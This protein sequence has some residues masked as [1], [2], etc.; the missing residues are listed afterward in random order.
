MIRQAI[1]HHPKGFITTVVVIVA[2][3][4]CIPIVNSVIHPDVYLAPDTAM[5]TISIPYAQGSEAKVKTMKLPRG[6]QVELRSRGDIQS[7]VE[8]K[9]TVF[10][11]DNDQ[12][13]GSLE[14]AIQVEYVYPRRL[15]NLQANKHGKLSDVVIRKGERVKVVQVSLDDF[16]AKT[17]HVAWYQVEKNNKTYWISGSHVE[18][19]KKAA[20]KNYGSDIYYSKYWDDYYGKG[21]SKDAYITQID[22]KPREKS[23]YKENP[24]KG[25]TNAVHVSLDNLSKHK[26]YYKSLNDKTGINAIVVELKSDD[27]HVSYKSDVP[28]SYLSKPKEALST[29]TMSKSDVERLIKEYQD[30]GYYMIA[31]IVSFKDSIFASQN[32]KESIVDKKGNLMSLNDEYWPTVYSRKAW[33]YNVDIAKEVAKMGIN[34]IQFD[35]CRF[36]DGLAGE[37]DA[38]NLRNKYDES[39]VSAIQGFL[40]YAYDEISQYHVYLAVDIFAWPVVIQDDNDIG[41][42]YPAVVNAVDVISP[43]PYTDLFA[44]GSMDID[45]PTAQPKKTLY[46]FSK[47]AKK[48]LANLD[49]HTIY[50]TW[51]QGYSPFDSEDIKK[52]IYGINQAKCEGYMVW[53]GRGDVEDLK[54][55]QKGFIDSKLE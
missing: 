21:Y 8:Y 22:Y 26:K 16:N 47:R 34:E 45:D 40:A 4:I 55:V 52:E 27:G 15:F 29:A 38:V 23:R 5:M 31:R 36:P 48:Q 1:N 18:T 14:E 30:D 7:E 19:S 17:G 51:I 41:Q 10:S 3:L 44:S 2:V 12:L 13:A 42:F 33:M 11:V 20:T 35:Y 9:G 53:Y 25:N 50:R 28:K 54:S 6:T 43:M 39:K 37:E 32:K 49:D 24:I 46:E